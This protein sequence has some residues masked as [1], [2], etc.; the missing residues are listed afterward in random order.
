M[1]TK[2]AVEVEEL[3]QEVPRISRE[4][5]KALRRMKGGKAVG[6]DKIPVEAW[7]SLGEMAV[8]WLTRQFNRILE[9]ERMPGEWRKSVLVPVFKYKAAATIEELSLMQFGF[10]PGRSTT[11]AIFALRMMMEREVQGRT[12]GAALCVYRSRI[13]CRDL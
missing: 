1:A 2:T 8:G 10:M 5:R 7:R 13:G 3:N 6:P 9:G 12:E 4:V 11:D